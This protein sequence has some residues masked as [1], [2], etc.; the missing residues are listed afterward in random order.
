MNHPN[1]IVY[2]LDDEP[3]MVK[4]LSRLLRAKRF[5]VR[6]FTSVNAFPEVAARHHDA[7]G[8]SRCGRNSRPSR[9]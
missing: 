1:A 9:S 6:G 7:I 8:C 3:E 5:E 2:L 4:A